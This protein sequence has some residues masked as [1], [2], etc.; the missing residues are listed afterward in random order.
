M[1]EVGC[2]LGEH[3]SKGLGELPDVEFDAVATMG[4]ADPGPRVRARRRLSW[5]VPAPKGMP[6]EAFRAVRDE[7]EKKVKGLLGELAVCP[8][9]V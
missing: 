7:I 6:P 2:D 3:R 5:D 1:H 9:A 4:G 8:S